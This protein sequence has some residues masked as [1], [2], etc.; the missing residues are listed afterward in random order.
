M[1][2]KYNIKYTII[3][4]FKDKMYFWRIKEEII[5]GS[6]DSIKDTITSNLKDTM[7]NDKELEAKRKVRHYKEA[8]NPTIDNDNY[9]SMLTNTKKKVNIARIRTNSHEL[10]TDNG[11][12][13]VT[14]QDMFVILRR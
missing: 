1:G 14:S 13:L 5:I 10:R 6:K 12:W 2:S 3:S 11:W 4:N 7:C 9:L 8:I